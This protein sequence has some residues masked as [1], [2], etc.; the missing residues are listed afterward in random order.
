MCRLVVKTEPQP[1][2]NNNSGISNTS[3]LPIRQRALAGLI[4][5]GGNCG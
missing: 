4:L 3:G 2:S 5:P 1:I